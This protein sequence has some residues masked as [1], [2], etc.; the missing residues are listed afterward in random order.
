MNEQNFTEWLKKGFESLLEQEWN[1]EREDMRFFDKLW[2]DRKIRFRESHKELDCIDELSARLVCSSLHTRGQLLVIFPDTKVQRSAALFATALAM[3]G[4]GSIKAG[5][6]GG[7]VIYFGTTL[8]IRSQLADMSFGKTQLSSVFSQTY[9]RSTPRVP[10]KTVGRLPSV[11]CV[12]S[13]LDPIDLIS[14]YQPFWVAIDCG[15]ATSIQW[16]PSLLNY[17]RERLIPVI[18]WSS[19][20]L[21][22]I[23]KEFLSVGAQIF[24]WPCMGIGCD[25]LDIEDTESSEVFDMF[26]KS[27]RVA[28]IVP[29]LING[30]ATKALS[31]HFSRAQRALVAVMREK[32]GRLGRDTVFAGWKYLRAL[33][34]IAIPI[35]LFDSEFDH[36]WG[37][38]SISLLR[39]AY[40]RF[41][42]A[43]QV[44]SPNICGQLEVI[45]YHL[46]FVDDAFR[47]K[48]P[49]RWNALI[50][51][52]LKDVPD[53]HARVLIFSSAAQKSMFVFALLARMNT[54]ESD[55][56]DMGVWLFSFNDAISELEKKFAGVR[57]ENTSVNSDNG[58]HVGPPLDMTWDLFH[59]AL[60]NQTL[61]EKMT[62]F[63]RLDR[64]EVL[65]YPHQ[66]PALS[67]L[68]CGWGDAL[69]N[70]LAGVTKA[71]STL[72]RVEAPNT[73]P[74]KEPAAR[75]CEARTIA[76]RPLPKELTEPIK[77]LWEPSSEVDEVASLFADEDVS[78]LGEDDQLMFEEETKQDEIQ[79]LI[80][81]KALEITF[82]D[83]WWGRFALDMRLNVVQTTSRGVRRDE[84]Y[85]R[86][87]RKGDRI[88][89]ISG[90]KRQSLY[91]LVLSRVHHHPSI[92]IH[93]A[94]IRQW[95]TEIHQ[96][97]AK[98]RRQG[99]TLGGLFSEM[100]KRGTQLKTE[101]APRFWVIGCTLRPRDRK[102]MQRIAEILDLPFTLQHYKRIH[103]AGERIHGLH[104]SLS[105]RLNAWIQEG[106]TE[107]SDDLIDEATGL[108]FRD[109]R[110]SLIL[111]RVES[112]S[113]ILGPFDKSG[114]GRIERRTTDE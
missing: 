32:P 44:G 66:L 90:Q 3:S 2:F 64:F 114:L 24:K 93:L 38:R 36:Y 58:V 104:I 112:V 63:F 103:A 26:T 110:D 37:I 91:E 57:E 20:P 70:D 41:V 35:D 86:S 106:A 16:V 84:R 65:L 39:H 9:G 88:I 49:P 96:A 43:V 60:P 18:A 54:S 42:S 25:S 29:C 71:L 5:T 108:T 68:A 98:W 72:T 15:D 92:E 80:V 69:G 99:K 100:R 13:P 52:C 10:M 45:K 111:L 8:G 46:D 109:L 59:V 107:M 1:W 78:P 83:G 34:R 31:D 7:C 73:L 87:L 22:S 23:R 30:W 48:A 97:Y 81:D 61:S 53:G 82:A 62:S 21:S 85:A 17:L 47:E 89:Y 101:V 79:T 12:Y 50:E 77:A 95:Q 6:E 33:E 75:E 11:I 14:R 27:P 40:E 74:E 51:L 19:N 102:D 4:I 67:R 113:E 55:L 105:R 94:L 76:G 28:S 56:A